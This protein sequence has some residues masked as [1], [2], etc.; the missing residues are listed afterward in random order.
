[1]KTNGLKLFLS[2]LAVGFCMSAATPPANE[3]EEIAMNSC[4]REGSTC[5]MNADCN[6]GN[7]STG[8]DTGCPSDGNQSDSAD[9]APVRK[10]AAR[11][12]IEGG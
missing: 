10:S 2:V 1:M 9:E 3:T 11:K 12:V 5:D 6:F 8:C 4:S 7:C